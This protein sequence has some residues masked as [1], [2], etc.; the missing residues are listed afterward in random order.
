MRKIP[1]SSGSETKE[2]GTIHHMI[3]AWEHKTETDRDKRE[4]IPQ[5]DGKN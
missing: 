1:I 2:K 4:Q 5:W 3:V